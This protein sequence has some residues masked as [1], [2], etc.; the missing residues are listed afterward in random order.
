MQSAPNDA[1]RRAIPSL[2]VSTVSTQLSSII[3]EF[4]RFLV[5]EIRKF[6]RVNKADEN[7]TNGKQ[8]KKQKIKRRVNEKERSQI[9]RLTALFSPSKPHRHGKPAA[10]VI[11]VRLWAGWRRRGES[12]PCPKTREHKHLRAQSVI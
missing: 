12:N 4:A 10:K 7:L 11:G 2:I 9:F 3:N 5:P 8:N 6:Y 1:I